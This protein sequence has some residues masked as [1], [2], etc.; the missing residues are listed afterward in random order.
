VICLLLN[1]H[2]LKVALTVQIA[3]NNQTFPVPWF[4]HLLNLRRCAI[5]IR[6]IGNRSVDILLPE[7]GE[8]I[9]S[10]VSTGVTRLEPQW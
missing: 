3:I 7:V 10:A 8:M 2:P 9:V 4:N 1:G 6:N 5:G